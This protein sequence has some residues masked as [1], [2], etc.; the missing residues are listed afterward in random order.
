MAYLKYWNTRCNWHVFVGVLL[1]FLLFFQCV[2][3]SSG[4]GTLAVRGERLATG[5]LG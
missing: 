4:G 5:Y 3:A 1:R 2:K